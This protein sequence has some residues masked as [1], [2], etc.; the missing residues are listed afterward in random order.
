MH[1]N[2]ILAVTVL[3]SVLGVITSCSGVDIQDEK[4]VVK[5][6]QGIWTGYD[7]VGELYMHYKIIFREDHFEGWIQT[8]ASEEPPEWSPLPHEQGVFSLSSVLDDAGSG[9]I[10]KV[11]FTVLGRC[12]GD[13][14]NTLVNLSGNITY[15]QDKGLLLAEEY[16]LTRI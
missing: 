12:C 10:R 8:S 1:K 6:M 5:D 16:S 13:K 4:A 15:H 7:K 14:S 9:K 11:K 3:F 2:L